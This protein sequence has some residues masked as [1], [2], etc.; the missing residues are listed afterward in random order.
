MFFRVLCIH[1]TLVRSRAWLKTQTVTFV[2][3]ALVSGRLE[4]GENAREVAHMPETEDM[5][6][7]GVSKAT[8]PA[9]DTLVLS[10]VRANSRSR[11]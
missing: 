2:S 4:P 7:G 6:V 3:I 5:A 9:V 10:A 11:A 1:I 8:D